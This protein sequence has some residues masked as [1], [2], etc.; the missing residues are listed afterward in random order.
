[1]IK[2]NELENILGKEIT[3]SVF[4]NL[5]EEL[6][7]RIKIE[8]LIEILQVLDEEGRE[9]FNKDIFSVAKDFE[10]GYRISDFE[11]KTQYGKSYKRKEVSK[12]ES[13]NLEENA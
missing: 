11:L 12:N 3:D 4:S 7:N 1:M 2:R 8:K 13:S 6:L 5:G 10:K 9:K